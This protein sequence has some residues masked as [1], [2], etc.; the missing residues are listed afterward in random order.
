MGESVPGVFLP[1]R[2]P[3]RAITAGGCA[4]SPPP[5]A[6]LSGRGRAALVVAALLV[7]AVGTLLT[8]PLARAHSGLVSSTPANG[9]TV[10]RFESVTLRFTEAVRSRFATVVVTTEDDRPIAMAAPSVV[11]SE[12][13]A[14]LAASAGGPVPAGLYIVAYR[15]VSAD[16]HPVTGSLAFT[17]AGSASPDTSSAPSSSAAAAR[18]TPTDSQ[19]GTSI[20]APAAAVAAAAVVALLLGLAVYLTRRNHREHPSPVRDP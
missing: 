7:C 19:S 18:P 4:P 10:D 1:K 17:V 15:V 8:A 12:V 11:G 5:I 9:A 3:H 2:S 16:G 6:G 20:Q 13:T 14:R